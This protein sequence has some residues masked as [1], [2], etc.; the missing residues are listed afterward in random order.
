M[1]HVRREKQAWKLENLEIRLKQSIG[2]LCS[3]LKYKD[4]RRF[5]DNL[6]IVKNYLDT[7]LSLVDINVNDYTTASLYHIDPPKGNPN[8]YFNK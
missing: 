1:I 5:R 4:Y 2:V 8:D 7:V 3:N 6:F